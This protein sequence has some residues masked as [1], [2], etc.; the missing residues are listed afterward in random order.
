VNIFL[1]FRKVSGIFSSLIFFSEIQEA[2]Y[3]TAKPLIS[4]AITCCLT[5]KVDRIIR[6]AIP[7]KAHL[8]F[9][10]SL[11]RKYA[12]RVE[13]AAWRLGKQLRGGSKE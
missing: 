9:G 3:A 5:N 7:Q 8:C 13:F 2:K 4:S 10:F 11:L 12:A 1:P 6:N